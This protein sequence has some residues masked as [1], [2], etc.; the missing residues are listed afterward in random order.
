MSFQVLSHLNT[1]TTDQ[2]SGQL[3]AI[4]AIFFVICF[5]MCLQ[6]TS[7]WKSCTALFAAKW[8]FFIMYTCIWGNY[9]P[10]LLAKKVFFLPRYVLPYV[11]LQ[12]LHNT[13]CICLFISPLQGNTAPHSLSKKVCVA[14]LQM[15]SLCKSC[16]ALYE[17]VSKDDHFGEILPSTPCKKNLQ[18]VL[19]IVSSDLAPHSLHMSL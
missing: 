19:P 15:T 2:L 4:V 7:L 13:L 3:F 9:S 16:T 6:I 11:S 5:H 18:Y 14:T 17:Y 10:T 12:I 8:L 1:L